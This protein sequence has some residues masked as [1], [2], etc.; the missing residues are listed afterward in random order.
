MNLS[1]HHSIHFSTLHYG[2]NRPSEFLLRSV[3]DPANCEVFVVL[4]KKILK[5][6]KC[7]KRRS[8]TQWTQEC[9]FTTNIQSWKK[10]PY[11]LHIYTTDITKWLIS[12]QPLG[13]TVY[14]VPP[15]CRP[16][17]LHRY[18]QISASCCVIFQF[19]YSPCCFFLPRGT[20][21]TPNDDLMFWRSLSASSSSSYLT[22]SSSSSSSSSLE[23]GLDGREVA[24]EGGTEEG[25]GKR[26]PSVFGGALGSIS[27]LSG[28]IRQRARWRACL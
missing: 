5:I 22:S 18:R 28:N 17:H 6:L 15:C 3:S 27:N 24:G 8:T 21:P 23:W 1:P 2:V 13:G 7:K 12:A 16:S 19:L 26:N 9:L 14:C 11:T 20:G 25:L 10:S 4:L